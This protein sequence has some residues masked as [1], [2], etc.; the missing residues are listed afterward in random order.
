MKPKLLR[1]MTVAGSMG[2]LKGQLHFLSHFFEVLAVGSGAEQ[3]A[4]KAEAEGVK[5]RAVEMERH[6]SPLKDL[7]SLLALIKLFRKERP[8]I[9]HSI[10]PKAGL[11]SMVAA[12]LTRV[13]IR[14]HTFTGL[15]WPTARGF[16]RRLLVTTDK[17]L[18]RCATCIIP[19]GEG[20]RRDMIAAR[21]S[22]KPLQILANGN[23]NGI[24]TSFFDPAPYAA[25]RTTLREGLG[26]SDRDTVLLFIGRLVR[27]KGINELVSVF[28]Q[29]SNPHVH[30]LLVGPYEQRL[31][32][33]LPETLDEIEHNPRITTTGY[34]NDVRPY[35]ALSD[36]FVFPSYREGFPNVVLQA[37][38]MGLPCLVTDIN[39]SNEIIIEGENGVIIPPRDPEALQQ[40][41]SKLL[42]DPAAMAAMAQRARPLIT[43]RYEQQQVWKAQLALY[44]TL[45]AECGFPSAEQ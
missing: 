31:D 41:L 11:L 17:L 12:R 14:I 28:K 27:D 7:R 6:I 2:L 39:G 44:R 30:L 36:L 13:P 32:P 1:V 37:G 24:N 43:A 25:R 34:Q 40:A 3:L 22:R 29:I 20:V 10:T 18:C 21:I 33:L 38:A 5:H 15:I 26:Y 35:L 16:K 19:E 9:V 23:V 8:L 42:T 45:I 4:Q